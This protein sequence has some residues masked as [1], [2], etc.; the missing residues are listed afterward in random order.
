MVAENII[1]Y[2]LCIITIIIGFIMLKNNI[3][4]KEIL[5]E[6]KE[7]KEVIK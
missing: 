7:I 1:A 3:K 4:K 6:L 2:S 5:K